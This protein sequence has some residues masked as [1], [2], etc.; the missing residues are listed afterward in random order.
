MLSDCEISACSN[1]THSLKWLITFNTRRHWYWFNLFGLTA[2]DRPTDA[3]GLRATSAKPIFFIDINLWLTHTTMHT[4][5]YVR[6]AC[7]VIK[8]QARKKKLLHECKTITNRR[9]DSGSGTEQMLHAQMPSFF[10]AFNI[11]TYRCNYGPIIYWS[12]RWNW[13]KRKWPTESESTMNATRTL[14]PTEWGNRFC[15]L[16]CD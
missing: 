10:L 16:F 2:A 8:T 6:F 12:L 15:Y 5:I 1:Q 4:K 7:Y 3:T 14:H 9:C 13:L 11:P